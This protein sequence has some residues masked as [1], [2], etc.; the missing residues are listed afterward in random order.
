M[1]IQHWPADERPREKLVNQGPNALSDAEL[2]AIFLRTGLPGKNAVTLAR[3]ILQEHDGLRNLLNLS[4]KEFTKTKGL[5]MAK[6]CQISAAVEISRRHLQETLRRDQVFEQP[7]QV[8]N[9]LQLYLRD[10]PQEVF[11]ALFLDNRHRL[12]LS[13]TLFTGTINASSVYPREVVKKALALNAAA[14]IVAHNHPSG[15]AEPS[16]A[17]RQITSRLA[18]ALALVEIRLLDHIVVGDG[19]NTSLAQCDPAL[20]EVSGLC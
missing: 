2:L 15:V 3:E 9:Y 17:D 4:A 18:R 20:F 8:F 1:T 13:E 7:D 19:I 14:V 10:K 5:G 11:V 16:T 6:Y 12:I